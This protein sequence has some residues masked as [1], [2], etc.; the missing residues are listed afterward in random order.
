LSIVLSCRKDMLMPKSSGIQ[1]QF[2]IADAQQYFSTHFQKNKSNQ[3]LMSAVVERPSSIQDILAKKRPLWENA[4][5]KQISLG[6][7]VKIPIDMG[8]TYAVV[9]K[10]TNGVVPF[11][12]LN[13]LLMYRDSLQNVH[14][15][16]V[17]LQPDSVWLYGDRS[18]FIGQIVVRT[19]EGR[20]LK[21]LSYPAVSPSSSGSS[22]TLGKSDQRISLSKS[23]NVNS[24]AYS[25]KVIE[26]ICIDYTY[27]V[28]KHCTCSPQRLATL[29]CD[30]CSVC[31]GERSGT[32]CEWPTP[33]PEC[34]LCEEP[35]L[36]GPGGGTG[37]DPNVGGGGGGG[38]SAGGGDY[39]P[40]C[41]SD[42]NY[43]MPTFPAPDGTDWII[44]CGSE[45]PVPEDKEDGG[46][47]GSG[48][49]PVANFL[50]NALN[51]TI[52]KEKQFVNNAGNQE[53]VHAL[54]G[55]LSDNESTL[56]S[57]D[58]V[59]WA[60]KYLAVTDINHG[61]FI[62][63]FLINPL[64]VTNPDNQDWSGLD[65]DVLFDPD[66]TVYQQYQDSK[67]WPEIKRED[68]LPF[69]KF[70]PMR[71]NAEG[72]DINCLVLAREQLGKVGY[73][74][75]GYLPASQTYQAYT[76]ASGVNLT[77]T[78]EAISYLID[79]LGKKIPVLIG[80]D[81]RLG[82]PSPKNLDKSTD[83]F[84]V[85]VGM[86]TDAVGKYFQFVDSS[87][88]NISTGASYSNRLYYNPATGKITGR[89][90]NVQYRNLPGMHD[91]IVT[92]VRKSI[93]K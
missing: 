54:V 84:V 12:S 71:K 42:P 90:A 80:V 62:N 39:P 87:T 32:L 53:V 30:L 6:Q 49:T 64:L 78:R 45:V 22:K 31:I 75:S 60:I 56:E 93:K 48:N 74:C 13:Y 89:T 10:K 58:F 79:A 9:N 15:E 14:T 25:N 83:H 88:N 85:I 55:Y 67:P 47:D 69:E 7:A 18:K 11:S 66:Q 1:N 16:W 4:Y 33:D 51:I 57:K 37:T 2:S 65:D 23:S 59:K 76:E 8:Q 41:N 19:W 73:T 40:S 17:Y 5:E 24:T 46:D 3:K 82:T 36:G 35:P 26:P 20:L 43:T 27:S 91:Y 52:L 61:L 29:G 92:Q 21:K 28:P 34:I 86:G 72:E 38:G 68:I 77:R 44:P 70:V 81:N 50:I 63:E